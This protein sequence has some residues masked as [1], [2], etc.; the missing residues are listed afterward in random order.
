MNGLGNEIVVV[1]CAARSRQ[2]D[3]AEA[4]AIG[5]RN[6]RRLRPDDGAGAVTEGRTPSCASTIPTARRSAPA[7]TACAAS[8][9]IAAEETGR[10]DVRFETKAGLLDVERRRRR[11]HHRRHGRAALRLAR[12][13]AGR[14]V[15]R[16][17]RH[18]AADRP[19]RQADPA[20]AVGRQRRQS[21]R[22]LLGRRRQRLR[23]RPLR[24][25]AGEPSDLSRARQHLAGPCHLARRP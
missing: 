9:G 21:A 3:A 5:D 4:R 7:A 25:D 11:S 18:R 13:P 14:A 8:A 1:D 12:H 10:N 24:A 15:P 20:F 2:L 19:D 22:H 16:H 17:A 23:S 6:R